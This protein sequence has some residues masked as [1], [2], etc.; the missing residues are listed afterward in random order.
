MARDEGC[1]CF[2]EQEILDLLDERL[3]EEA[4]IRSGQH[5]EACEHCSG[6]LDRL[7]TDPEDA[8]W[9]EWLAD[10]DTQTHTIVRDGATVSPE[11]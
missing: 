1:D 11:T 3:A 9:G 4:S 8:R 10:L 6:T 5:V 2:T 7:A